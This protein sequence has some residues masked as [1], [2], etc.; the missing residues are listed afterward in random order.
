MSATATI[1]AAPPQ[2][3]RALEVAN[4]VR[5][6]R[7][8]TKRRVAEGE[9][10]VAEVVMSRPWETESMTISDLLLAQR[11]WGTARC[12]KF[13]ATLPMSET[14]TLSSMTERQRV[15]LAAMLS[16]KARSQELESPLAF[17]GFVGV[18]QPATM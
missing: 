4:R 14:K 11:R 8:E 16:A 15:A 2:H 18:P 9:L 10:T 7:A 1:A 12:R 6:A 17:R 13:L 3:M 5:L